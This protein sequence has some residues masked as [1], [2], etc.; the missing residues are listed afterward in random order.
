MIATGELH[1]NN[2]EHS[3]FNFNAY[4]EKNKDEIFKIPEANRASRKY[5]FFDVITQMRAKGYQIKLIEFAE[6]LKKS[7]KYLHE[8]Y[9]EAESDIDETCYD[10]TTQLKN[11]LRDNF[12][13]HY[14]DSFSGDWLYQVNGS[15]QLF[16]YNDILLAQARSKDHIKIPKNITMAAMQKEYFIY[17]K[18]EVKEF[19]SNLPAWSPD[20][21][22]YLSTFLDFFDIVEFDDAVNRRDFLRKQIEKWFVR[23]IKQCLEPPF[24]NKQMLMILSP[25]NSRKT[26]F[27]ERALLPESLQR[28]IFQVREASELNEDAPIKNLLI[29]WDEFKTFLNTN[30][31]QLATHQIEMFKRFTGSSVFNRKNRHASFIGTSNHSD[32]I[33]HPDL[34]T[35]FITLHIKN[36]KFTPLQ[37]FNS[38]FNNADEVDMS[39]F[40]TVDLM[41]RVWAQCYYYFL[42]AKKNK[43]YMEITPMEM[44]QLQL[45]NSNYLTMLDKDSFLRKHIRISENSLMTSSEIIKHL[46]DT[47]MIPSHLKSEIKDHQA[48]GNFLGNNKKYGYKQVDTTSKVTK[49]AWKVEIV[50]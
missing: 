9:I 29:F 5:I 41:S 43:Y 25:S 40:I 28:L 15:P 17:H 30:N 32:F 6:S 42:E 39:R 4:I 3:T 1:Y 46:I 27:I 21:H 35:R 24:M 33:A 48:I 14:I 13:N 10:S 36:D 20:Q 47:K 18:N 22:D 16:D 23:T 44:V 8:L 45:V 50:L 7:N 37:V 38:D 49:K 26:S 2:A 31:G 19:L 34:I 11:L 12:P